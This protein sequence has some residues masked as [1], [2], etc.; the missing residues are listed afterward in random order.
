VKSDKP[1]DLGNRLFS[2]RGSAAAAS[3]S[4]EG[5][6]DPTIIEETAKETVR[7]L[8]RSGNRPAELGLLK[9]YILLHNQELSLHGNLEKIIKKL[10]ETNEIRL[11]SEQVVYNF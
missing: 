6:S 5:V 11:N 9:N 7:R 1:L 8:I 2:E 4:G 10:E 3:I